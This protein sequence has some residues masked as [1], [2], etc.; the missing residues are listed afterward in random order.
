MSTSLRGHFLIANKHLKDTNFY[1]TVVLLVEHGADGAMGVVVNRPS[2]V[3]VAHALSEHFEL[4]DDENV[5]FLGGPV[6]PGALFI[7]HNAAEFDIHEKP[8]VPGL[9]VNSSAEVFESVMRAAASGQVG[10]SYRVFCGCA[11]WAPGQLEGELARGDWY[12]H[13]ADGCALFHVDPYDLWDRE[14]AC[15]HEANR[16]LPKCPTNPEWN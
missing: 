6:E 3:K 4:P 14:V 13:R 8:V 16:I 11:G 12:L 10:L 9:Y 5:V 7:L 1:K 15:V 2:S